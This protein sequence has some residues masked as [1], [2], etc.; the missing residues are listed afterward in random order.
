MSKTRKPRKK[1]R[2]QCEF[3]T[4]RTPVRAW[5]HERQRNTAKLTS[6]KR[7]ADAQIDLDRIVWDPEYRGEVL[8]SMRAGV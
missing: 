4:K 2:Q 5:S 1:M 7:P 3:E 6:R 8:A